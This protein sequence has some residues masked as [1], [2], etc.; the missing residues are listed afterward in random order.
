MSFIW[1]MIAKRTNFRITFCCGHGS[2]STVIQRFLSMNQIFNDSYIWSISAKALASTV[3]KPNPSICFYVTTIP[4]KMVSSSFLSMSCTCST[5]PAT[6]PTC[7]DI[8]F[9]DY[10]VLDRH[11]LDNFGGPVCGKYIFLMLVLFCIIACWLPLK[12][13]TT[14]SAWSSINVMLL[15]FWLLS[16]G[17]V[18]C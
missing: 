9:F 8:Y 16:Y 11:Q 13:W 1:C 12:D 17:Y 4:T 18:L 6:Q 7:W 14:R 5:S 10:C 2:H 15:Y 3:T